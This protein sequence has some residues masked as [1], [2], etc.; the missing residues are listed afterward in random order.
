VFNAMAPFHHRAP[1][2]AGLALAD[3]R[4]FVTLIADGR[5]VEVAVARIVDR[6]A[7]ERLVLVSDAVAHPTLPLNGGHVLLDQC[8]RNL[9]AWTGSAERAIHAATTAP[10]RFARLDVDDDWVVLDDDLG[11][12]ET[13]TRGQV[14]FRRD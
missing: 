8:V 9:A 2:P 7:G 5:H 6:A 13:I 14:A 12:V 3:D 4:L 1:G 10:A 11:V